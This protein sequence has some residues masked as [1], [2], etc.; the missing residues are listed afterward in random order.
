LFRKRRGR[1]RKEIERGDEHKD[2]GNIYSLV[3]TTT[4]LL[5]QMQRL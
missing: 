5:I 2:Q 4:Y 1:E 3:V